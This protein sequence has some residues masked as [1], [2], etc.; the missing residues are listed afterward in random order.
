MKIFQIL[1]SIFVLTVF[2]FG[3]KAILTGTLCDATGAVIPREKVVAA[4]EKGERFEAVTDDNG[5]YSLTLPFNSYNAK[6]SSANF[7]IAKFE[8]VVNLEYR[9]FE[10]YSVKEFKFVPAYS[11]KMTF[12][13]A[14]DSINSEPCGYGGDGCL[15]EN[16]KVETEKAKVY[17]KLLERPLEQLL[18]AKN[19]KRKINKQ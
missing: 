18:K 7:R 19:N 11:G 16:T 10:K 17:N 5:I 3:Q 9:G 6:K 1:F 14:L 4:S 12:D 13:I 15:Q 8:I 2:A